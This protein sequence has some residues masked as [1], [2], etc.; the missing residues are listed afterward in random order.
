[1]PRASVAQLCT[2]LSGEQGDFLRATIRVNGAEHPAALLVD[3]GSTLC[4][5]PAELVRQWSL[6]SKENPAPITVKLADGSTTGSSSY[7][8]TQVVLQ[9]N[10]IVT[11]ARF[12]I[13]DHAIEPILGND[14]LVASRAWIGKHRRSMEFEGEDGFVVMVTKQSVLDVSEQK[15][16][17]AIRPT[18]TR[19]GCT[20]SRAGAFS[21]A[22][23][24][25]PV[26][27]E[28]VLESHRR[29]TT[30]STSRRHP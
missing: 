13:L 14:W 24:M 15:A 5:L 21:R 23:P 28:R 20:V 29:Q 19:A 30:A 8:D 25:I 10:N 22:P 1:M 2:A 12:W 17:G 7:V 16:S 11:R 6:T 3:T 26:P 18:P 27:H 4:F 9:P